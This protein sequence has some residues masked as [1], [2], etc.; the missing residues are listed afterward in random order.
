M[1]VLR[2]GHLSEDMMIALAGGVL[3]PEM[4]SAAID[5]LRACGSCER[6]FQENWG[7]AAGLRP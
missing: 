4:R 3:E 7:F 6:S 5:H 1:S 2:N